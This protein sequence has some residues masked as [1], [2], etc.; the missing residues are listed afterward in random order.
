MAAAV[1]AA[2]SVAAVALWPDGTDRSPGAEVRTE[3]PSAGPASGS[4]DRGGGRSVVRRGAERVLSP[5][6]GP[7]SPTTPN[8]DPGPD[9]GDGPGIVPAPPLG[10][11]VAV[12]AAPSLV[13]VAGCGTYGRVSLPDT[14]GVAYSLTEGDGRS[15]PWTVT[16]R[17][18]KGWV[19]APGSRDTFSGDLGPHVPCP[20]FDDTALAN[21]GGTVWEVSADV[22]AGGAG[23][24]LAAV[25]LRFDIV[26]F[27]GTAG[28]G[29]WTCWATDGSTRLPLDGSGDYQLEPGSHWIT[30]ELSYDGTQPATLRATVDT[31]LPGTPHGSATAS[32]DG[33]VT[34]QRRF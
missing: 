21:V 11:A 29:G 25:D 22:D 20:A 17:A 18:Q 28:G 34:A 6:T 12:P 32:R 16:A 4:A 15:G 9:G 19:L 13:A 33:S 2:V 23:S 8:T 26:V 7:V 24:Y 10:L 14:E 31:V 27:A 3:R 5:P 1:V 30:C